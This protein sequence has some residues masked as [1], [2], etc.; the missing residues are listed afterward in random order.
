MKTIIFLI[1]LLNIFSQIV[2]N[3]SEFIE[4]FRNKTPANETILKE[5]IENT[6]EFL[7][8]YI[9]YKVATD[10]PQPDFDKSYFPK[11]DFN[12]LFK[13]IKTKDTNYFIL[14]EGSFMK[15]TS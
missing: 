11:I 10:P 8:H 4:D 2:Y 14:A 1:C 9:F 5:A 7:K 13:D 3:A 6:K 15:F 12:S